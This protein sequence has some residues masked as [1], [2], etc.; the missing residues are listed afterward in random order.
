MRRWTYSYMTSDGLR[1]EGEM[2]A[3]SKDDVYSELRK[4]GIRAI[5]VQER[6]QPVVKRGFGGLRKRDWTVIAVIAALIAAAVALFA[7]GPR[8]RADAVPPSAAPVPRHRSAIESDI[9]EMKLGDRL[10]KAKARRQIVVSDD[11]L[12]SFFPRPAE[13]FLAR[14]ASP[15]RPVADI[16]PDEL[17]DAE[18][19]FYDSL[20]SDIIIREGDS[21]MISELKGIVAGIK[22][23]ARMLQSSGRSFSEIAQWLRDRQRMETDYRAHIIERFAHDEAEANRQLRTLG[24]AETGE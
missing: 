18:E 19:D 2:S 1:H 11:D 23:E 3:P 15:G 16:A 4:R 6:I 7:R 20:E 14:F 17:R 5:K 8:P 13:R 9:V 24:L 22:D 10:A 12:A 21:R